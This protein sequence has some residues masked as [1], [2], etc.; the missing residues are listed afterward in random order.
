MLH[1]LAKM[2]LH[3]QRVEDRSFTGFI[4]QIDNEEVWRHEYL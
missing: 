1:H 2:F 3:P 4:N